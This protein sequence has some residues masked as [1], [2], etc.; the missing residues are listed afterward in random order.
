MPYVTPPAARPLESG[1]KA[2]WD[3]AA[4]LRMEALREYTHE[5]MLRIEPHACERMLAMHAP[6]QMHA[7]RRKAL[8]VSCAGP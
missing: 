3:S 8:L 6:S 4:A 7:S 2:L 5:C 1:L